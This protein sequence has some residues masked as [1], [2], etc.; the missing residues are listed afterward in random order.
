VHPRA[1][2]F[3]AQRNLV[4]EV[5]EESLEEVPMPMFERCDVVVLVDP[6]GWIVS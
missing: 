3:V 2:R 6:E 1:H 5:R 4:F